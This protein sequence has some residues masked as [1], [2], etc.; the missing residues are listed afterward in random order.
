MGKEQKCQL[1]N[2]VARQLTDQLHG[3]PDL[4]RYLGLRYTLFLAA[5]QMHPYSLL[6]KNM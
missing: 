1:L 6:G 2:T 4:Y 5:T 3:F